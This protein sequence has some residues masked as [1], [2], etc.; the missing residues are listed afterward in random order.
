MNQAGLVKRKEREEDW[1]LN[2]KHKE[3]LC[4]VF[5]SYHIKYNTY[6]S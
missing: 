1:S 6:N 3:I 4:T 2:G 5:Q